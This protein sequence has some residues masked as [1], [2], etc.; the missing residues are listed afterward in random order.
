MP[1]RWHEPIDTRRLPLAGLLAALI[2][3]GV[4]IAL[5]EAGR[6]WLNVPASEHLLSLLWVSVVTVGAVVVA[7]L[8]MEL[9]A[10]TQA[11]P[12]T[13][14]RGFAGVV[15]LASCAGPLLARSGWIAAIGHVSTHTMAVMLLMH[16]LSAAVIV[17]LLTTLPRA[18]E[19]RPL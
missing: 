6:H 10:H 4:N 15:L 18:Y 19:S 3:V 7:T 17:I 12:V 11:R 2:A 14:F 13:V 1:V 5:R 16:L 8:G 9:F